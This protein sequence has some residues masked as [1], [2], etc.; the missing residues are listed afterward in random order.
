[1]HGFLRRQNFCSIR[2]DNV[3]TKDLSR[4]VAF[5]GNLDQNPGFQIRNSGAGEAETVP[6]KKKPWQ[7]T[8]K[9]SGIC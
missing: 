1:V 2:C 7:A 4:I 6:G 3:E 5:A 9:L 8:E